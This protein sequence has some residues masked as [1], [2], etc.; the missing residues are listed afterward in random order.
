MIIH[1]ADWYHF[2]GHRVPSK[3]KLRKFQ[4]VLATDY[5]QHFVVRESKY[6]IWGKQFS[7]AMALRLPVLR[8]YLSQS[9]CL[10]GGHGG[11]HLDTQIAASCGEIVRCHIVCAAEHQLDITVAYDFCP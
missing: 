10:L 2:F 9:D 8:Y 4:N 7:P 11:I 1:D 3:V 5:D 6:L